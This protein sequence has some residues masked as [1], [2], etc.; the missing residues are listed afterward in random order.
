[1]RRCLRRGESGGRWGGGGGCE[2][3]GG[4]ASGKAHAAESRKG[5][6]VTHAP[7][8]MARVRLTN[9]SWGMSR[10][11]R[12]SLRTTSSFA[13]SDIAGSRVDEGAVGRA[14]AS[15]EGFCWVFAQRPFSDVAAGGSPTTSQA[16]DS[17]ARASA[18]SCAAA[19]TLLLSQRA[20]SA[21]AARSSHRPGPPRSASRARLRSCR[22]SSRRGTASGAAPSRSFTRFACR[23]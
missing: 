12:M 2:R 4:G 16:L 9:A 3:P 19:G 20:T 1:M 8:S 10:K 22:E 23:A 18:P 17:R 14:L 11:M 21:R 7:R 5:A 6:R 15:G 13:A